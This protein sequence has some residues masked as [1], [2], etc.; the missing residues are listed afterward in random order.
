MKKNAQKRTLISILAG[1]A[2]KSHCIDLSFF[3]TCWTWPVWIFIISQH[4]TVLYRH[5]R[6]SRGDA[7]TSPPE[8]G[9]GDANANCTSDFCHIGTKKSVLLPSKYA[10]TRFRPALCPWPRWG[11]SRRSPRP[12]SRLERGH[13]SPYPTAFGTGPPSALT[14]RPH[15]NSSQI[16]AYVEPAWHH[17]VFSLLFKKLNDNCRHLSVSAMDVSR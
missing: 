10:K 16:Y 13:P 11:S 9:V 15:Q 7:G 4:Q 12:P 1:C 6:G 5:G 14:M 2:S 17:I 3:H 8:F